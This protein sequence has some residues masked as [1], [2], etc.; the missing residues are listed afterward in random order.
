MLGD[1]KIKSCSIK[2]KIGTSTRNDTRNSKILVPETK[3]EKGCSKRTSEDEKIK[4]RPIR[5]KMGTG[6][7]NN[8]RNSKILV[9]DLLNNGN[10]CKLITDEVR[11]G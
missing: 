9:P 7:K 5:L 8:T 4:H 10:R 3:N 6:T 1:E 2:L 11:L